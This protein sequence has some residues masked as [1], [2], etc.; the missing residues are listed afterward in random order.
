MIRLTSQEGAAMSSRHFT[1]HRAGQMMM[2]GRLIKMMLCVYT[3]G[4]KWVKIRVTI[5]WE[6]GSRIRWL[7]ASVACAISHR[8]LQRGLTN[9]Q[10]LRTLESTS[11]TYSRSPIFIDLTSSRKFSTKTINQAPRSTTRRKRPLDC[12]KISRRMLSLTRRP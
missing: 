2:G 5:T 6:E 12:S 10:C 9:S 11:T 4:A 1:T 8:V 3:P 7:I